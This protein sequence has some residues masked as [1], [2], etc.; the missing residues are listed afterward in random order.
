MY[1]RGFP[2]SWSI[3]VIRRFNHTV[4]HLVSMA[5]AVRKLK[6]TRFPFP[7]HPTNLQTTTYNC[8]SL[9][10]AI[11]VPFHCLFVLTS[12]FYDFIFLSL[13]YSLRLKNKIKKYSWKST[14]V[15][16]HTMS[17]R[18]CKK[19]KKKREKKK[20]ERKNKF[21]TDWTRTC[22]DEDQIHLDGQER[23]SRILVN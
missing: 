22:E 3:T 21:S 7:K 5:V 19:K 18:L 6:H 23:I 9:S 15:T 2:G 1:R 14:Y 4:M 12:M 11:A 13:F 20:K 8:F 10:L 16:V 17:V